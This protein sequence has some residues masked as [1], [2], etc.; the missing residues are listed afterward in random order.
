MHQKLEYVPSANCVD[1]VDFDKGD[2]PAVKT[3]GVL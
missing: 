1:Q 2:L 3:L